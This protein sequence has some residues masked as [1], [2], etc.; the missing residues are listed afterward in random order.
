MKTALTYDDVLLIPQYSDLK[1][2]SE[3]NPATRIGGLGLK[4]PILS[5]NMDSITGYRMASAMGEMGGAGVLHRF[6]KPDTVHSWVMRLINSN[7]PAIPSV[8]VSL[9]DMLLAEDYSRLTPHIC[10][11]IAHGDSQQAVKMVE[12]VHR[13][14]FETIIAGNVCTPSGARRLVEAGANVIKCGIGCGAKCSTREVSGHGYP[15]LSAI[16]EINE[17]RNTYG[18]HFSIIADGGLNTSGDIV[19]AL[20]AGADAIMSGSLFAGYDE[21]EIPNEYRGMAS[22]EAQLAHHGK[23]NNGAAEGT[24]QKVPSKGPVSVQLGKLVGGIRSGMSYSGARTL[25]ELRDNAE[26]V[27]VSPGTIKE[28]GTRTLT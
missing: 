5:A 14:G 7:L 15:Q 1:S 12:R 19:K 11:D 27:K 18:E 4:V 22:I 2:R 23:V 10:I 9:E 20:A 26:W 3:A 13:L 17:F 16:M 24:S 28:N 25:Q 21:A 8:G 6:A